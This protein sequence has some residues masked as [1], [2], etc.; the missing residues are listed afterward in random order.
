MPYN[1]A[2]VHYMV[3]L[4]S[5]CQLVY[6]SLKNNGLFLHRVYPWRSQVVLLRVAQFTIYQTPLAKY[7]VQMPACA[8]QIYICNPPFLCLGLILGRFMQIYDPF[9]YPVWDNILPLSFALAIYLLQIAMMHAYELRVLN[10]TG[11]AIREGKVAIWP[12]RQLQALSRLDT[13]VYGAA[14]SRMRYS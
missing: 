10:S 5:L 1:Y 6:I 8:Y 7:I 11:V 2:H 14:V 9:I 4:R 13:P 12:K 3:C